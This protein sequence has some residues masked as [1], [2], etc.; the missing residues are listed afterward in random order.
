MNVD[1]SFLLR[2]AMHAAYPPG[3]EIGLEDGAYDGESHCGVT[4]VTFP[5]FDC[6]PKNLGQQMRLLV[7]LFLS[8]TSISHAHAW[9]LDE[10]E[11]SLVIGE[12]GGFIVRPGVLSFT[13]HADFGNGHSDSRRV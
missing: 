4:L 9:S 2:M 7:I 8:I 10:Y 1:H 11:D 3:A 6:H 12:T 13:L 5:V